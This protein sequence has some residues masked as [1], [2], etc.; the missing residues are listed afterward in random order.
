MRRLVAAI[1]VALIAILAVWILA[2]QNIEAG[3]G[4]AT[5]SSGVVAPTTPAAPTEGDAAAASDDPPIPAGAESMTVVSVHD[6]DTLRLRDRTGAEENVRII[7]V[8]TP[9]V[10]PDY[11]CFGDE[12]TDALA[13]LAP[14]GAELRVATDVDAFD[15]YDRLL[16][17]LWTADGRFVNL[18]LVADGYAEAIRV[19]DNDRYFPLLREAEGEAQRAGL[20]MWGSC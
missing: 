13:R 17:Y 9:E 8:D 14:V 6:G 18:A 16:L 5:G 20:G 19:G 15:R 7:G 12:A 4:G 3:A 10:Y 1:A 2:T 11:E